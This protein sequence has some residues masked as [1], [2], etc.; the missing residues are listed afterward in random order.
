MPK[1]YICIGSYYGGLRLENLVR[2][3]H[4]EDFDDF[5]IL[6]NEQCGANRKPSGFARIYNNLL[7]A[8]FL[9][10]ACEYAWVLGDDVKPLGLA[11]VQREIARDQTIGA[12]FPVE[13]WRDDKNML[14]TSLPFS[15]KIVPVDEAL[16]EGP[17][18]IEQ[19]FAGFACACISRAAW[20][21][22]GPM[23]ESLGRGYCEDLDWGI[24]LW[25]SGYRV[26]NYRRMW[27][28]HERGGTYNRLVT[29]NLFRK[30]EP[31]EAA[32]R[33]KA[34]WPWLWSSES[35]E[36]TMTRLR[37]AYQKAR[38]HLLNDGVE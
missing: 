31:Y 38:F 20:R 23:D 12:L 35:T 24:R 1:V 15:G 25:H 28:L 4:Q 37:E 6:S 14:V 22:V 33:V 16:T 34:K 2:S 21:A 26:V 8:A 32:E 7:T 5:A 18:Q 3:L 27:F 30:E 36:A 10:P 19:L 17:D 29:E 13:A 11:T 9:D